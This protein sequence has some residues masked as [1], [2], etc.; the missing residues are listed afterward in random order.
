MYPYLLQFYDALKEDVMLNYPRDDILITTARIAL[1]FTLLFSYPVLLHPTR[2]AINRLLLYVYQ[3]TVAT[4][5]KRR[6]GSRDNEVKSVQ[7]REYSDSEDADKGEKSSLLSKTSS[8]TS[9]AE[10]KVPPPSLS[11][12]RLY[13]LL[14]VLFQI[15]M[16]IWISETWLLFA[17]TFLAASYIP[18]VRWKLPNNLD[19][20]LLPSNCFSKILSS[21][22]RWGLCGT[23]WGPS[24]VHLFSISSP[25]PSFCGYGG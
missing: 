1:F 10:V 13:L 14:S 15:P 3:L 4:L 11:P 16:P 22:C 25:R 18:N 24:E 19:K 17:T 7:D 8:T 21:S 23:L 6:S 20:N 2:A 12:Y 5:E 9:D